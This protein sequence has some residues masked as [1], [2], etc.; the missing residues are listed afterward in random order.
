MQ[1]KGVGWDEEGWEESSGEW[2][3]EYTY[4]RFTFLYDRNQ[5]NIIKQLSSKLKSTKNN[6]TV[7]I[8]K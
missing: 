4:D 2:G 8:A 1:P 6:N 7:I 3:H 5:H